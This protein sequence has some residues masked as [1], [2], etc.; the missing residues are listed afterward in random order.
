MVRYLLKGVQGIR[1]CKVSTVSTETIDHE[2]TKMS[3][4]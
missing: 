4:L 1:V 2:N 3:N